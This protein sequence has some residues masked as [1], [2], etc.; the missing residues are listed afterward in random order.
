MVG[1]ANYVRERVVALYI[2]LLID[3]FYFYW[4][5]GSIIIYFKVFW[6]QDLVH[7]QQV[8]YHKS[9]S[10][11][12]KVGRHEFVICFLHLLSDFGIIIDAKNLVSSTYCELST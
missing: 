6:A 3:L 9:Q 2:Y 8:L 12:F 5:S 1:S 11:D 10:G 4:G 7:A